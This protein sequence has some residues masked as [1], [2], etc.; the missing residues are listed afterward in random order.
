MSSNKK[1]LCKSFFHQLL[2]SVLINIFPLFETWIEAIRAMGG[3]DMKAVIRNAWK[4]VMD[5]SL[6]AQFLGKVS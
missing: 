6:M 2:H 1:E 3:D 5:D 4:E